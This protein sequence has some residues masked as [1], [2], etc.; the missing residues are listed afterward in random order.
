M[1]ALVIPFVL[2]CV[3]VGGL[4]AATTLV[5]GI[6]AEMSAWGDMRLELG[7]L[8]FVGFER[9]GA[10]TAATFGPGLAVIALLAGLLNAVGAA[11]LRRRV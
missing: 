11:L 9:A 3:A 6:V 5:L 10:T 1:R 4:V 2:G 8:L 7:L